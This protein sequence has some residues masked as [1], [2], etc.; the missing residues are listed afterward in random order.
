MTRVGVEGN[1]DHE[2]FAVF[3]IDIDCCAENE[4]DTS[5]VVTVTAKPDVVFT[6]DQFP[7]RLG[8]VPVGEVVDVKCA[9]GGSD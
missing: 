6:A 2:R 1:V 4:V 9:V 5:F 8:E 3:I 7:F